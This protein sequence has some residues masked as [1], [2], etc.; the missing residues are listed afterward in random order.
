MIIE[1]Y[2]KSRAVAVTIPSLTG[3]G[4]FRGCKRSKRILLS[5]IRMIREDQHDASEIAYGQN[6]LAFPEARSH[7]QKTQ[8]GEDAEQDPGDEE[9]GDGYR[10]Y[11]FWT[12]ERAISEDRASH[13]PQTEDQRGA[14]KG[15]QVDG[16][17]RDEATSKRSA[18]T[19]VLKNMKKVCADEYGNGGLKMSDFG[20]RLV[21]G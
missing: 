15:D 20:S 16:S 3:V 5:P 14:P 2:M 21:S 12:P 11:L 7:V 6:H 10:I 18:T 13:E 17:A 8:G 19:I 4:P 9:S 1:E